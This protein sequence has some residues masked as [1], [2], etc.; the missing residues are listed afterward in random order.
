MYNTLN[1]STQKIPNMTR[2]TV[3]VLGMDLDRV[4]PN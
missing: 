3:L 2:S 1:I 4:K